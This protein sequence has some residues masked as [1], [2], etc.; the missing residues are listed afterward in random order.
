MKRYF[1]CLLIALLNSSL[2]AQVTTKELADA[3]IKNYSAAAVR[4]MQ[5]SKVP[6]SITL[7]QGMLE[8]DYSRSKLAKESKNH[9]GIKC[10]K[11]WI[12]DKV[13]HDDD[14]KDDCF[15][16]YDSVE[17]SYADHSDF[18]SKRERYASLFEL[19]KTDYKGWA[20]GLKK[21]GYATDPNYATRLIKIIEDNNLS[22]FDSETPSV[23]LKTNTKEGSKG[24]K[25]IGKKSSDKY[26]IDPFFSHNVEYNN[27]V[28]YINVKDGD[29][30]ARI[31]REFGL[32]SWEL[33]RYNDLPTLET[34]DDLPDYLYI[35]PKKG[36]AHPKHLTHTVKKGDTLVGISNKYGL[37]LSKLLSYNSLQRSSVIKEGTKLKLRSKK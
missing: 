7:A 28:K 12:G 2:F 13:Y 20:H 4:E 19:N 9:F 16:K 30:Y 22:R 6:A 10:G 1:L 18:L 34:S 37:K 14:I 36:K 25:K 5:R 17:E 21:A 33:A 31:S 8:S 15:R 32:K 3:Y 27:G 29:T 24:T 26:E 11:D 23:V 35:A